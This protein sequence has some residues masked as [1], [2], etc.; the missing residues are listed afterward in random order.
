MDASDLP[1]ELVV[2]ILG[3][4]KL[5]IDTLRGLGISPGKLA[6]P[7]SIVLRHPIHESF[8][9]AETSTV[10]LLV[11]DLV[12]Y[13]LSYTVKQE[14]GS[15][16]ACIH[17]DTDQNGWRGVVRIETSD[18]RGWLGIGKRPQFASESNTILA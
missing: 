9:N 1:R 7:Q 11:N 14:Y 2:T 12:V 18:T 16:Y 8:R 6:I 10:Y 13:M 4:A 3:K 15:E 5:G 17:W